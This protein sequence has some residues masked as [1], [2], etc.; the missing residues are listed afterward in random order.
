[1]SVQAE[2]EDVAVVVQMLVRSELEDVAAVQMPTWA[3]LEAQHAHE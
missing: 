3:E 1:M 2:L